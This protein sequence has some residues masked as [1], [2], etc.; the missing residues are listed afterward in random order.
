MCLIVLM[1]EHLL[2]AN[3]LGSPRRWVGSNLLN[4]VPHRELR[5]H[6]FLHRGENRGLY[7]E[8]GLVVVGGENHVD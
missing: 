1:S 2:L 4:L 7:L 5:H 6:G 8:L 3:Q